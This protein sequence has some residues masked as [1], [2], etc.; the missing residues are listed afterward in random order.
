MSL[1]VWL[2]LNGNNKNQGLL[3]INPTN[4]GTV[5]YLNDGKIGKCLSA[6]ISTQTTNGISYDN[7]LVDIL[8][9]KFS[10]SIWV[11]PLGNHVHYNGTFIS[12]GNWNSNCWSF[13]V[14]QDNTKVDIFSKNYNRYIDCTVPVNQWTHLV[15]TSDDGLVKLYKNGEYIGQRTQSATLDTDAT[16]FCVGRETYA[17]GYFSF[18][19]NIND[20]RIYDH[21]LSLKEVKE[22]SK[23]LVCH[24]KLDSRYSTNN[25]IINGLG[26]NGAENWTSSNYISTTEIP[27]GHSEIKASYYN[28]NMTK[29]YIPINPNHS[30]TVSAYLK[31]TGATT[32]TTYPSIYPYD[33]DKKFIA[34][35]NSTIGFSNAYK[36]TLA[37]P[38]KKGD[39]K[40]YATNLSAW[41]TADTN[42][43]FHVAI[44]GYKDSSGYVYPDM[45]YTADSPSFGSKTD[46][47][48]IDKTNNIITLKAPFTGEYR[49]AGTTI[50]QAT[51]G[52]TYY[53]PF[54]GVALANI[55]DWTFKTATFTPKNDSRLKAC[56]YVKWQAYSGAYYAGNQLI[57][58]DDNSNIIYDSS[59]YNYHAVINGDIT[60]TLNTP[61]NSLATHFTSGSYIRLT[62]F[63]SADFANSY[64]FSWWGKFTQTSNHM[65]WGYSNG[66]R[67][68]LYMMGG[69]FYWNTGDGGGNPFNVSASTYA[70]NM[71]HHM[72]VTG[73]GTTTKLYIDGEFKNNAKTYKPITGTILVLN[74][75][76]AGTQYKFNGDLSDFRIYA[77]ALSAED[78]KE[79]YQTSA[80]IDKDGNIFAYEFKED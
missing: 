45:V 30:Y 57:D 75:W 44:F 70:D 77:T 8:G 10:C 21:V 50:C 73:D 41:T 78:V 37:Q 16:N 25:L 68:N 4:L 62:D 5:S 9:T 6:G 65:M 53:Y 43:Y 11:R 27:S 46:K 29:E 59:G 42:Y 3:N 63:S 24:Y 71:W 13:G 40:I 35:Y 72:A 74:G 19:G 60:I 52:A 79:L 1:R 47:S 31:T 55:Q 7:N 56:K 58:N 66:N 49:P 2:P 14:N 36:T 20:V 39:T 61:R 64:T 38:L 23:G 76:D 17:N 28:S 32:G 48:N 34:C 69:N 67:L 18:N 15:C 33:Y 12:S 54:G 80:S 26:E 51:E 22:I